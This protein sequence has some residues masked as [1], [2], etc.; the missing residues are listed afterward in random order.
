MPPRFACEMPKLF[1]SA[2]SKIGGNERVGA[3]FVPG[4]RSASAIRLP[5]PPR[6]AATYARRELARLIERRR[7]VS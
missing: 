1:R 4:Y 2:L 5:I 6:R 3:I 7:V